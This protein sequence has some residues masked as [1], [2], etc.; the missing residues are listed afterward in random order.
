M[1][2]TPFHHSQLKDLPPIPRTGRR[3]GNN[4]YTP[5]IDQNLLTQTNKSEPLLT[6]R[7]QKRLKTAALFQLSKLTTSKPPSV[8]GNM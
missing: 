5:L 4:P 2:L 1:N 3:D 7:Y 6:N 8:L